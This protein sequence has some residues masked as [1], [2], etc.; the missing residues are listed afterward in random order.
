MGETTCGWKC[1]RDMHVRC[2]K[3]EGKGGIKMQEEEVDAARHGVRH[4]GFWAPFFARHG[5][6]EG[7][8]HAMDGARRKRRRRSEECD[9]GRG[10]RGGEDD[11]GLGDERQ[12]GKMA[13]RPCEI[14]P[15]KQVFGETSL[16]RRFRRTG[17]DR[18][19]SVYA[20]QAGE[21]RGASPARVTTW[22]KGEARRRVRQE[23]T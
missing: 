1:V 7:G 12:R 15:V 8:H 19:V 17:R 14:R 11:G 21:S 4:G 3:W 10:R 23:W 5:T 13:R 20:W 9:G 6:C 16:S 18:R 2:A 22:S